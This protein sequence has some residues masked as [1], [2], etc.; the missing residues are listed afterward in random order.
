[1]YF[2]PKML[3]VLDYAVVRATA[4]IFRSTVVMSPSLHNGM[5]LLSLK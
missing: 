3:S 2:P 5:H 1:M 4:R